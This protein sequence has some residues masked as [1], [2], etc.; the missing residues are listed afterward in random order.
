MSK[1]PDL[2]VIVP[3]Y[4][5]EKYLATCLDSLIHQTLKNI[6]IICVDD[7]S[8]DTSPKILQDY[9]AT[10]NRIKI[11]TKKNGGL[12]S[13]RNAGLAV[14]SSEFV[15]FVD[16]DDTVLPSAYEHALSCMNDDIDFVQFGIQIVDDS[17]HIQKTD[18]YY[19]IKFV[20]KTKINADV[21]SKSDVSA[22]N[23]IFRKSVIDR[24]DIRFPDGLW[25]EDA[26]FFNIY[27][28]NSMFGFY[29]P[30][31]YYN[32]VRRDGSIM[33]QTFSNKP[34][35][36]I[37]HLVI[38]IRIYEYLVA[39]KMFEQWRHYFGKIFFEYFDFAL[40]YE[41]SGIGRKNIYDM[42][43][44]FLDKHP[45]LFADF[46]EFSAMENVLRQRM[47]HEQRI[48]KLGGLLKIKQNH[49]NKK[50]YFLG[51]P[52]MRVKFCDDTVRYYPF[53]LWCVY[54]K[55]MLRSPMVSVLMPVYNAEKYLRESIDSVLNQT[56]KNFEFIIIN[57]GST[58]TSPDI[59]R[60][61]NDP[62]IVFVDN[63]QN[64]GLV[65][66]LNQGLDLA[67]GEY[68]A[69]MDADDISLPN[70]F[71]TQIEFM[72]THPKVGVLGASF[73]IFG[74][75]DRIETKKKYPNLRYVLKISPVGHPTVMMRR[76]VIEKYGLRYD[77]QY[78]H[79]E[80]YELWMRIL[81]FTKIANMN[82]VLLNYRWSGDN[83]S[84]RHELEQYQNSLIIKQK[85]R[86][87]MGRFN[88]LTGFVVDD[89]QILNCLRELGQ[90][91]YMPNSGNVGDM[92]IASATMQWFDKN[93]L[94]YK[95]AKR[96]ENPDVLVYGGGGAWTGD[97]IKYMGDVMSM[98]QRAKRVVILPSSFNNVPEFIKMLDKRFVVFCREQK[99]FDYLKSANTGA[100]I[101]LDHD[102]ALRMR[103]VPMRS[104]V[105]SRTLGQK[106]KLLNKSVKNIS[107]TANLF[108]TD[109]ESL[110]THDTDFD[111]SDALGWFSAYT[112]RRV[113]D[114]V[115]NVMLRAVNC[116]DVVRTD[117]LH[118]GIA[119]FLVGADVEFYDNSYGKIS[120]VYN[121]SLIKLANVKLKQ[122]NKEKQYV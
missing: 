2:S 9:A 91:T 78:K 58:D 88:R 10:D 27:A 104:P 36:S 52:L 116:F 34:G 77:P 102:M 84:A 11:V 44:D 99:S 72:E 3:V 20:G 109:A 31:N 115:A 15:A 67:H 41:H 64:S 60:S 48:K 121:N 86:R 122:D 63:K 7:G 46:S 55:K 65:S 47:W 45:L 22:C 29:I 54:K 85:V 105:I 79:A 71:G 83:V 35:H 90:F 13:A 80:D 24:C 28:M 82:R 23:K 4:N 81:R 21:L 42:A 25:Y 73:H 93:K 12:S 59:V 53:S 98:M 74:G 107:R 95:R 111:L 43:I 51:L 14:A 17:G 66:V 32:Y 38:A 92:L 118:V 68:I 75:I 50:Y 96:N 110:E 16:S 8:T 57:D 61:Y 103:K 70:R 40:R 87:Q 100:T 120:G 6:E 117:R 94:K 18:D 106:I 101:L 26:Y 39:H 62:R 89:T 30:D 108:R 49:L 37:D 119:A 76:S 33:H 114:T 97:Y 69:R 56:Y 113:I 1:R 112:P 19:K 5:V